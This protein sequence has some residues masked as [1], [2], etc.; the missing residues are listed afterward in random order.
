MDKAKVGKLRVGGGDGRGKGAW[1]GENGDYCTWTILKK[2]L[3]K[4]EITVQY[5]LSIVSF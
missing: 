1:R 2:Y 4:E 3:K 5:L